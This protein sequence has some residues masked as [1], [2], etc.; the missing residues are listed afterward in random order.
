MAPMVMQKN[1]VISDDHVYRYLL[2]RHWDIRKPVVLFVM[3][4]PSTADAN[5]DDPT[6]RRCIGFA[7]QM[8]MGGLL[9]GNLYALRSADPQMIACCEDPVG[10]DNDAYLSEMRSVAEIV[11]AAWGSSKYIDRERER[12]V[13]GLMGSMYCLR[14]NRDGRPAHPL[15][16][17]SGIDPTPYPKEQHDA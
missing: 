7:N 17:P 8:G 11:I 13:A 12:H 4:N 9:V 5:A 15:Y 10:Q 16:V 14:E 2:S 1:A 3:L 6:I